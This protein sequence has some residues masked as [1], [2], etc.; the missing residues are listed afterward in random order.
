MTTHNLSRHPT[1]RIWL[2]IKGRCLNPD[3]PAYPAYGGRGI[4]LCERWLDPVVFVAEVG[5]KP[6]AHLEIDRIDND[7]G[8][9]PGNI[10][11][12]TRSE[13]DRNRRSNVW[14]EYKGERRLSI[15]LCEQFNIRQDTFMFRLKSG[16]SVEEALTT[17]VKPKAPNGS[18]PKPTPKWK[19]TLLSDEQ[20][21]EMHRLYQAGGTSYSQLAKQ[22]GCSD[23]AVGLVVKSAKWA[24]ANA[25]R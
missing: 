12:A 11:W 15:E 3:H 18:R 21:R 7:K 23:S 14:V 8:Y 22:F 10:R 25:G 17:P 13:N 16:L 4:T 24:S 2:G 9:E 19:C 1:Y 6:A 20:K 5:M